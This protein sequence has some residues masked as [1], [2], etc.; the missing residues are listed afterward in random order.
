[1]VSFAVRINDREGSMVP[2]VTFEPATLSTPGGFEIKR[3]HVP[4]DTFTI[5]YG[6]LTTPVTATLPNGRKIEFPGRTIVTA[7]ERKGDRPS[8]VILETEDD[9]VT[10]LVLPPQ[11]GGRR[12]RRSTRVRRNKR[13]HSR[14]V[15]RRRA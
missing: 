9:G 13:R 7:T 11:A 2:G 4:S 1:M 3:S 12:H 8:S 15:S 6:Y 5:H 14:R 10:P